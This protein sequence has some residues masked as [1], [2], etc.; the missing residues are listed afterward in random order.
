MA[1]DFTG[2]DYTSLEEGSNKSISSFESVQ[3]KNLYHMLQRAF[4][5]AAQKP[6]KVHVYFQIA[7]GRAAADYL[8]EVDG[9]V[10]DVQDLDQTDVVLAFE[11]KGEERLQ[12]LH[13]GMAEELLTFINHCITNN[14]PIPNE[15]W[16]SV[17]LAKDAVSTTT[18][19]NFARS[20]PNV[21][22]A[23]SKWKSDLQDPSYLPMREIAILD[24]NLV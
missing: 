4:D 16:T 10:L 15:V 20:V 3:T 6:Q 9:Q 19:Y 12:W 13:S 7:D 8:F 11:L 14:R 18:A 24:S 21:K 23:L 22:D 2:L 17:N 5:Y 1:N